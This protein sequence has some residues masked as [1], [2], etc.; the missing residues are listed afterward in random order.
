MDTLMLRFAG[1]SCKM[2]EPHDEQGGNI[3]GIPWR[4]T[5]MRHSSNGA[6]QWENSARTFSTSP[7]AGPPP[8]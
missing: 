6:S 2:D 1:Q 5:M 8:A 4:A 7:R 3:G